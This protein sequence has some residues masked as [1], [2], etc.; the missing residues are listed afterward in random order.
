[1]KSNDDRLDELLQEWRFTLPLPPR[2]NEQVW[3]RIERAE[4]P[5]ISIGEAVRGWFAIAFARPAFAYAYVSALLVIGLT[6]GAVQAGQQSA[7]WEQQLEASYVQSVDPY[8]K[9]Q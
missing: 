5:G 7:R 9:G 4:I 3:K 1:M 6:L 8:Q 2:F